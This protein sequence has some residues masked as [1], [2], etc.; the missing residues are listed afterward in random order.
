MNKTFNIVALII[1]GGLM[2]I[3]IASFAISISSILGFK[4]MNI[5]IDSDFILSSI[6]A[7]VILLTAWITNEQLR[8]TMRKNNS[9]TRPMI[10]RDSKTNSVLIKNNII[11]ISF[12]NVGQMI[13]QNIKVR[14]VFSKKVLYDDGN[15]DI[16]WKEEYDGYDDDEIKRKIISH[17][18]P[19]EIFYRN[20]KIDDILINM[21]KFHFGIKLEYDKTDKK[22]K[23]VGSYTAFFE[24]RRSASHSGGSLFELYDVYYIHSE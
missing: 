4:L 7:L 10:T 6:S 8:Q 20:F 16:G 3:G 12:V 11:Y 18:P 13:A 9:E 17:I 2:I 22:G 24:F 14:K 19:K 23:D 5:N 21:N 1:C 15:N